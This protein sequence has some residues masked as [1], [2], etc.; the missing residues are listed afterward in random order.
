[1]GVIFKLIIVV[2]FIFKMCVVLFQ[3]TIPQPLVT[4]YIR[5]YGAAIQSLL[6]REVTAAGFIG[7]ERNLFY[8][9]IRIQR[10]VYW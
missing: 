10:I 9:Y 6:W 2:S 8:E 3:S 4:M 5:A 7:T 1:M